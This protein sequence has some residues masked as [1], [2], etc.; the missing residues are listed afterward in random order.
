M[1]R[2]KAYPADGFSDT[3][4]GGR[5][6]RGLVVAAAAALCS[7]TSPSRTRSKISELIVVLDRPVRCIRSAR[8][9]SPASVSACRA[10]SRPR[11]RMFTGVSASRPASGEDIQAPYQALVSTL[12]EIFRENFPRALDLYPDLTEVCRLRHR[13]LGGSPGWRS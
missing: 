6:K 12:C 2:P 5:P 1:S 8:D 10:R 3:T 9:T 7:R 13:Q 4:S 11:R